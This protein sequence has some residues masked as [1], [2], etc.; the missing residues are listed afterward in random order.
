MGYLSSN[1]PFKTALE[2][3]IELGGLETESIVASSVKKSVNCDAILS[4]EGKWIEIPQSEV[5]VA[6]REGDRV[7][8]LVCLVEKHPRNGTSVKVMAE[9]E[10]PYY[11]GAS[12][13]VLK[14]L[15]GPDTEWRRK[16]KGL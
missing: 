16:A 11:Y 14:A 3:A 4:D 10:G 2:A 1:K 15:N 5:Y 6:Y 13:K 7:S 12:K 9:C 8:A